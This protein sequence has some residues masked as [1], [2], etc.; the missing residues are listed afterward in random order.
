MFINYY[1]RNCCLQV[2]PANL[3]VP[4]ANLKALTYI[5][6]CSSLQ[7]LLTTIQM[8][9][10]NVQLLLGRPQM[11]LVNLQA[12]ISNLLVLQ[13]TCSFLLIYGCFYPTSA[14]ALT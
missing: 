8:L 13:I 5:S 10:V 12:L 4:L 9:L 6:I 2:A 1:L 14:G 7:V 3:Q 11:P